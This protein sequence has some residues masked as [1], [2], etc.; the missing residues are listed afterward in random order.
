MQ[1]IRPTK[2]KAEYVFLPVWMLATR[3][4]GKTY[5]FA[6]NG[7]SGKVVGELPADNAAF[8]R[9]TLILFVILFVIFALIAY[10]MAGGF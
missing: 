7:Q 4:Q 9:S 3:Y 2:E 6:I 5:Q 1:N 10:W 8:A